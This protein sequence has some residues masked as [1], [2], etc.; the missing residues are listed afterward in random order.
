MGVY[1]IPTFISVLTCFGAFGPLSETA[2]M[3]VSV[4]LMQFAINCCT[5]IHGLCV[6]G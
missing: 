2:L 1:I 6:L 3:Q 4:Q 5:L